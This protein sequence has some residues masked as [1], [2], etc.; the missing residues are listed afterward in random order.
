MRHLGAYEPAA[1][2]APPTRGIGEWLDPG[3]N[4]EACR[5][6]GGGHGEQAAVENAARRS[7]AISHCPLFFEALEASN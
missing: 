5:L 3:S 2:L 4:E 7:V 1:G 6:D